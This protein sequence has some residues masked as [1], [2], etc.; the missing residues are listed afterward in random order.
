METTQ[1]SDSN[2]NHP[3]GELVQQIVEEVHPAADPWAI[4]REMFRRFFGFTGGSIFYCISAVLV[5]YGVA[6]VLAPVLSDTDTIGAALPCIGTLWIYELALLGVLVLIVSRKVVDDAISVVII[7]ALYLVASSIAAGSVADRNIGGAVLLAF[8]GVFLG[9]GKLYA[10][11]R[12]VRIPFGWLSIV[13]LVGLVA[14]NYF[15]P[16]LMAQSMAADPANESGRRGVWFL[17]WLGM[18]IAVGLVVT[19]AARSKA[20]GFSTKNKNTALLQ[21]SVM[22]YALALVLLAASGV[23]QYAMAYMFAL[24]KPLGD[25]LPATAVGALLMLEILRRLD[26]RFGILHIAVACVPLAVL[27][28]AIGNKSICASGAMGFDIIAYPPVF[29]ALTGAGLTVLSVRHRWPGLLIAVG[30]CLLG[31]ILTAGFSPGEPHQLNTIACGGI[32]AAGLMVYG[33][34]SFK[35]HFCLI[36]VA[37]MTF[38]LAMSDGFMDRASGWQ[39]TEMGAVAGVAGLGVVLLYIVFGSQL[40]TAARIVGALCLAGFILDYLPGELDVQYA[41]VLIV[42]GLLATGIWFRAR[43]WLVILILAAPVCIRLYLLAKHI[44][45]WRLVILGFV[46]LAAGTI[47]SLKKSKTIPQTEQIEGP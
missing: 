3:E 29:C 35:Q 46:V 37:I 42:G 15:G 22:P 11:R 20:R 44:T 21:S 10:M 47:L 32:V 40:H 16:I 14:A 24:D 45:H 17:I 41:V 7:M 23:H 26:L 6:K 18:L 13:G 28:Y 33:L 5:A 31:V 36:A 8:A 4:N 9:A 39:L 30:G 34:V 12:Y 19:E 25:F 43:D 2:Q 1:G 38:G 27:A